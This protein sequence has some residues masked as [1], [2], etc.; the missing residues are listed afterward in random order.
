MLSFIIGIFLILLFLPIVQKIYWDLFG[1]SKGKIIADKYDNKLKVIEFKEEE[2]LSPLNENI[3]LR[4]SSFVNILSNGDIHISAQTVAE[5][6]TAIKELKLKKKEYTL[7]KK[8]IIQSQQQIRA[9]YTDGIR[10]D[11]SMIRGGG[12]LGR[13]I[14]QLEGS[15]RDS[16]RSALARNLEPL[17][18]K[19]ISVKTTIND[20]D[21]GI[22][23]LEKLIFELLHQ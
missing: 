9:E 20:I 8:E 16:K 7:L 4:I 15:R 22:L 19:K 23:Q 6:K 5:A 1:G 18:E 17:E 13:A 21:Q 11:G 14:R 12:Q 3:S 10:R 2:G